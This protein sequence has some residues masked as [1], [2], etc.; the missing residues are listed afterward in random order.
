M[1][2]LMWIYDANLISTILKYLQRLNR[3]LKKTKKLKKLVS[4]E[5]SKDLEFRYQGTLGQFD[6]FLSCMSAEQ[7]WWQTGWQNVL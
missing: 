7:L 6:G 5:N 3:L 4:Y 2:S 1:W